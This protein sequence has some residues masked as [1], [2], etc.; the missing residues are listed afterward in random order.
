MTMSRQN[1]KM[2][3]MYVQRILCVFT[4]G[5]LH[6]ACNPARSVSHQACTHCCQVDLDSLS[7]LGREAGRRRE[8]RVVRG[9]QDHHRKCQPFRRLRQGWPDGQRGAE[10]LA[11]TVRATPDLGVPVDSN[12]DCFP[13]FVLHL[14]I[15]GDEIAEHGDA[16]W[17]PR[18]AVAVPHRPVAMRLVVYHLA[19]LLQ[20]VYLVA[21][22]LPGLVPEIIPV[23]C[24]SRAGDGAGWSLGPIAS[25]VSD[26]RLW[27]QSIHRL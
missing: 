10:H 14:V 2:N 6:R 11:D 15:V 9:L 16:A 27:L 3:Q 22:S 20:A 4:Q 8:R 23:H 19:Q 26:A 13:G 24:G 1:T 7:P 5:P 21:L 17:D 18:Q 25:V 12:L